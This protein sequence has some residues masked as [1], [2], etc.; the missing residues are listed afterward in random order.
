MLYL[1]AKTYS[2]ITLTNSE[3]GVE[4]DEARQLPWARVGVARIKE[5]RFGVDLQIGPYVGRIL[6]PNHLSLE[7]D[8]LVPGTAE[9]CLNLSSGGRRTARQ[10][11][12]RSRIPFPATVA[13]AAEFS[14]V[15]SSFL[16]GGPAKNY[17]TQT[18]TSSLPRGRTLITPTVSGPWARGYLDRV[19]CRYRSLTNDNPLNRVLLGAAQRAEALLSHQSGMAISLAQARGCQRQLAGVSTWTASDLTLAALTATSDFSSEVLLLS[20][21]L[22]QGIPAVPPPGMQP[23]NFSAWVNLDI[24]FEQAV[25]TILEEEIPAGSV[26]KGSVLHRYVLAPRFEAE[27][28]VYKRANPDI[29]LLLPSGT[30]VLD[31]KYR[32]AGSDVSDEALYQLLVHAGAFSAD[33][34]ALIVPAIQEAPSIRQLGVDSR[35]CV[36]DV[37]SVDARSEVSMRVQLRAWLVS[38]MQPA[39]SAARGRPSGA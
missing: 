26:H 16:R 28:G 10:E 19:V 30:A 15:A 18:E 22:L 5:S 8:E 2:T 39:M 1:R 3:L 17:V 35:G 20:E 38:T 12:S 34:A 6:V 31:A 32:R 24:L 9:A 33:F 13:I 4:I 14:D 25:R 11:S 7:I 27:P 37:V 21:V 36:V 29:V 23:N